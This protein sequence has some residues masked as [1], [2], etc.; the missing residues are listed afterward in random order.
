[1]NYRVLFGKTN[2]SPVACLLLHSYLSQRQSTVEEVNRIKMGETAKN[3]LGKK[4]SEEKDAGE[5]SKCEE[6]SVA[7]IFSCSLGLTVI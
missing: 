2:N 4:N 1:M 5:D 7:K 3:N 6:T